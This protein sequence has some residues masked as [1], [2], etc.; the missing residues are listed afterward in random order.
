MME[1]H[2]SGRFKTLNS[3]TIHQSDGLNRVG[4]PE[5][6]KESRN[7]VVNIKYKVQ[8]MM[9]SGKWT[10]TVHF[11]IHVCAARPGWTNLHRPLRSPR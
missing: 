3:F 7:K 1:D 8:M 9:G 2:C 6:V 11:L 10:E 5:K 4:V